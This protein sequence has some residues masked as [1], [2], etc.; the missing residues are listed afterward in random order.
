MPVEPTSDNPIFIIGMGRSGTT[1]LRSVLQAH[2]RIT[3]GPETHFLYDRR[4]LHLPFDLSDE[5]DFRT[6]WE[7]YTRE[8]WWP[9]LGLDEQEVLAAIEAKPSRTAKTVLDSLMECYAR[10]MN[11]PRWGEK[12]PVH[13]LHLGEILQWYPAARVIFLLRDPRAVV[14]SWRQTPWGRRPVHAIADLW[15]R[16]VRI[17]DT[18]KEDPRVLPLR[19]E[20]FVAEPAAQARRICAHVGE[21]FH[22]DMLH[23]RDE[24][25]QDAASGAWS[26]EHLRQ[27]SR[28]IARPKVEKWR[29]QMTP[30]QVALIEH[31]TEPAF[32]RLGYRRETSGLT[33]L[34][35]LRW[36]AIRVY[37]GVRGMARRVLEALGFKPRPVDVSSP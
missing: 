28:P 24:P 18:W 17:H 16:S 8:Q 11:K 4:R 32:S 5:A 25:L 33:G 26:Q 31:L 2:P 12:T 22:P 14:A 20:D 7:A 15:N 35:R 1:L 29:S 23:R 27:A 9:R 3:V 34:Q 36:Q 6:F 30:F 21:P 10:K 37:Y 13:E 19:F